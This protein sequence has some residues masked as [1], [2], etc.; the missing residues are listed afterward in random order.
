M[1]EGTLIA[2]FIAI[3][4]I[5]I[6]AW[7]RIWATADNWSDMPGWKKAMFGVEL[8]SYLGII[9]SIIFTFIY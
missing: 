4:T 6:A 2:V 3:A 5:W 8:G 7:N 9:A 1:K